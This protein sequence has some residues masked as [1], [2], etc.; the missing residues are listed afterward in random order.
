M[1]FL[2][3][4]VYVV[5][6]HIL[7]INI[8]VISLWVRKRPR[9]VCMYPWSARAVC[10]LRYVCIFAIML[11]DLSQGLQNS[12]LLLF[13]GLETP[14]VHHTQDL[15]VVTWLNTPHVI[16]HIMS[17]GPSISPGYQPWGLHPTRSCERNKRKANP[18]SCA[19]RRFCEA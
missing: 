4:Y 11:V 19:R 12:D 18:I 10:T 9:P 2:G 6:L 13:D 14:Q 17:S 5:Y 3:C 8:D 1:M 15:E 7:S 16:S